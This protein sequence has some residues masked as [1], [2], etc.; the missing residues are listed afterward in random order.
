MCAEAQVPSQ[1][2]R[3]EPEF[4]RKIVAIHMDVGRFVGLVAV[5]IK[6]VRSR[7]QYSWHSAVPAFYSHH[8]CGN[9]C[10]RAAAIVRERSSVQN[11][12]PLG[13]LRHIARHFLLSTLTYR[14]CRMRLAHCALCRAW[15]SRIVAKFGRASRADLRHEPEARN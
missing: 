7:P 13:Y 11:L 14:R 2:N 4:R 5:E 1:S 6:S 15:L 3:I 12:H 10:V 9:P 8:S